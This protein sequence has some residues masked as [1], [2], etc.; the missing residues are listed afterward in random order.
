MLPRHDETTS[1][2]VANLT[3]WLGGSAIA[4]PQPFPSAMPTT[5][6]VASSA[7]GKH[8]KLTCRRLPT[9]AFGCSILRGR[10]ARLFQ[11]S[12]K[13]PAFFRDDPLSGFARNQA[14]SENIEVWHPRRKSLHTI[15]P[16][17][18]T[19]VEHRQVML[20][21]GQTR[22]ALRLA[23]ENFKYRDL[24]THFLQPNAI[25]PEPHILAAPAEPR[26]R[27]RKKNLKTIAGVGPANWN[28]CLAYPCRSGEAL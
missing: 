24:K 22:T 14:L 20:Q 7:R 21:D 2:P 15:G 9:P 17:R 10:W 18:T 4:R 25:A 5:G 28:A 6:A 16:L 3:E 12:K 11:H 19:G 26:A 8:R 13:G 23:G 27:L 1:S